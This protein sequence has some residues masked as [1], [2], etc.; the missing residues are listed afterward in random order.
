MLRGRLEDSREMTSTTLSLSSR[1]Q[2]VFQIITVVFALLL[3]YLI[4]E[5]GYRAYL[6]YSYVVKKE[7]A[8]VAV[9]DARLPTEFS[10]ASIPNNIFGSFPPNTD[11]TITH[12]NPDNQPHNRH[13][14][15]SNNL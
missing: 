1:R 11:F 6:Y 13:H 14:V 4:V 10:L 9:V 8:G 12:Y 2:C 5:I 7:Y 3:G 15:H